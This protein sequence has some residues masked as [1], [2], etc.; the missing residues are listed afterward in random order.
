MNL[1]TFLV[2]VF[3]H[4]FLYPEEW[5]SRLFSASVWLSI[6]YRHSELFISGS[7]LEKYFTWVIRLSK[8]KA[9]LILSDRH[10]GLIISLGSFVTVIKS[11]SQAALRSRIENVL[12]SPFREMINGKY[13]FPPISFFPKY[14]THKNSYKSARLA[15]FFLLAS[16]FI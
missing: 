7:H 11:A 16:L 4:L 9:L 14:P 13:R 2:V 1:S 5:A 15:I 6:I 3:C 10:K 8:I 12:R